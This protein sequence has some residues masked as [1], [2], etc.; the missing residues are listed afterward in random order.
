MG[1]YSNG[2]SPHDERNNGDCDNT[3][4]PVSL[5]VDDEKN[6]N[7]DEVSQFDN[8]E[9]AWVKA[10]K[11]WRMGKA[12]GLSA[13]H[14]DIVVQPLMDDKMEKIVEARS[15]QIRKGHRRRKKSKSQSKGE[16]ND[17]S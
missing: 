10:Q 11:I 12:I 4:V 3:N 13:K 7:K 5:N 17:F 14:D 9:D 15:I 2:S 16:Q 8:K 6:R 1:F